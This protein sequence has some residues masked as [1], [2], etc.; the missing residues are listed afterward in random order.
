MIKSSK[1]SVPVL[2]MFV[3]WSYFG[4]VFLFSLVTLTRNN[5]MHLQ[6]LAH[7]SRIP[8]A[9]QFLSVLFQPLRAR[10][11]WSNHCSE[12]ICQV[13]RSAVANVEDKCWLFKHN[14]VLIVKALTKPHSLTY[15]LRQFEGGDRA[16]RVSLTKHGVVLIYP[17]ASEI[18]L[19]PP[20]LS[21]SSQHKHGHSRAASTLTLSPNRGHTLSPLS[22]HPA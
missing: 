15:T 8:Q 10:S 11:S 16:W 7:C 18:E 17:C 2:L 9:E 13:L 19:L 6:L 20:S 4:Q 1:K 3:I 5:K 21:T 22:P 12:L 14:P